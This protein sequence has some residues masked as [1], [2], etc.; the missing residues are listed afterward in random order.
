MQHSVSLIEFKNATISNGSKEILKNVNLKLGEA[1]FCYLVGQTGSGKS[2]FLKTIYA[3]NPLLAG[4]A[5][6]LGTNLQS[7]KKQEISGLR[8]KMGLIFQEFQLF[9]EWSVARNLAYVLSVTD[10]KD[11]ALM[12]NRIEEVLISVGLDHKMKELV[13]NLS[14]GEQQRVAIARAILNQPQIIIADEP[15]A[16]LDPETSDSILHVLKDVALTNSAAVIVATHDNRIIEKFPARKFRCSDN[17]M[18]EI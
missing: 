13:H 16:N 6:V 9:H 8:R 4:E 3:E 15:T 12:R 7:I 11:K 14:G 17:R 10:W 2:S 5:K 18:E 1:E